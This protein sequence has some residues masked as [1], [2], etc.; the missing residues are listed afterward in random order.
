MRK[1]HQIDV[2]IYQCDVYVW[3]KMV[4]RLQFDAY[5]NE[6][7]SVVFVN[8]CSQISHILS[9]FVVQLFPH[10]TMGW[11]VVRNCGISLYANMLIIVMQY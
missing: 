1:Y 2:Y 3:L 8:T 9:C 11:P 10:C 4:L 7:F 6:N 5:F